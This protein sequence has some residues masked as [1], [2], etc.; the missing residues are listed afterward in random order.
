MAR[1]RLYFEYEIPSSVVAVVRAVCADYVR[2]DRALKWDMLPV[3]VRLEYERL[4]GAI[5][6][7]LEGIEFTKEEAEELRRE[8]IKDI[9]IGRGYHFSPL[10]PY[11]AKNTYYRRKRKVIHDVAVSLRLL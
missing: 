2:R 9:G 7:S 4:N 11:F 6:S 8:L 1:N 5:N 3:G 10:S